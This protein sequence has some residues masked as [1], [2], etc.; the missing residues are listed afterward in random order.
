MDKPLLIL[1]P[2]EAL[3]LPQVARMRGVYRSTVLR[4]V[5]RGVLPAQLI[6]GRWL[7]RRSDVEALWPVPAAGDASLT[8]T[9]A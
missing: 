4:E 9:T 2:G 6:A 8:E 1:E 5:Q 3:T 7:V